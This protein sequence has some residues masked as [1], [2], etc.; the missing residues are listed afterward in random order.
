MRQSEVHSAVRTSVDLK[1]RPFWSR[2]QHATHE[3]LHRFRVDGLMRIEVEIL[4]VGRWSRDQASLAF[5]GV[6]RNLVAM[7]AVAVDDLMNQEGE[8]RRDDYVRT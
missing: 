3:P 6:Q 5:A 2:S 4:R 8:S 1:G 7:A